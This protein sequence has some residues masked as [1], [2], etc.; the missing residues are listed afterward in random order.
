VAT[1]IV[2]T[3]VWIQFFRV[4]GSREHL[5]VAELV[6]HREVAM[7]GVVLAELLQGARSQQELEE[8]TRWLTAL[9]YL[10]ETQQTWARVG[11]L[12]FLLRQRGAGV[13]M[14]DLVIAALA[15]EHG[16]QVY[17]RDEHFQRVPGVKLYAP[18]AA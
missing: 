16:C 1:V 17:T 3:S 18:G 13:P 9:P 11:R 10:A 6:R 14:L 4:A 7:V 5:T 2:D 12:S 8:L 15:L